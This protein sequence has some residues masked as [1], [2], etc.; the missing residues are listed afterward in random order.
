MPPEI[1]LEP[2]RTSDSLVLSADPAAPT[3][4][5]GSEYIYWSY[6]DDQVSC[7]DITLQWQ[8]RVAGSGDPMTLTTITS[9]GEGGGNVLQF[10]WTEQISTLGSGTYEL[11]AVVTDCVG[12]SVNSGSFY[13]TVDM[14]PEISTGPFRTSDDMP[15]SMDP[16]APTAVVAGTGSDI[17][18]TYDDDGVSCSNPAEQTW[19][20]RVDDTQDWTIEDAGIYW[21]WIWVDEISAIT[22]SGTFQFKAVA[23]DCAGQTV[24][25]YVHYITVP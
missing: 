22:G 20:Y 10:A 1:T 17:Y 13:F 15:L 9:N 14:P 21:Q 25:S 3:M 6:A 5:L 24:E 16:A 7:D 11:Q 23:T 19:Q 8:Y 12:Q 4:V 2:S 18:W